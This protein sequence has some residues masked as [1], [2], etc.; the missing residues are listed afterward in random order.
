MRKLRSTANKYPGF[1]ADDPRDLFRRNVW[2]NPFWEDDVEEVVHHMGADRVI[3]GS[4][5]PHIEGL[6]DPT[7]YLTELK[8]F[9]D[10]DVR[11]IMHDNVAAL[12]ELKPTV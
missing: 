5:W 12:T 10:A 2:I 4:D 9:A 3:F 6:P 1:F 7:A 8:P 11:K